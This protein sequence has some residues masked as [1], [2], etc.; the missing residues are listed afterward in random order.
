MNRLIISMLLQSNNFQVQ[1]SSVYREGSSKKS[2][3]SVAV[4]K[5]KMGS[6]VRLVGVGPTNGW[7]IERQQ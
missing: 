7:T 1:L 2:I 6:G 5:D 3:Q 4:V